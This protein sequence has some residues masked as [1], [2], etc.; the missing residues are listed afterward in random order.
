MA[1]HVTLRLGVIDAM[2]ALYHAFMDRAAPAKTL[3]GKRAREGRSITLADLCRS[4]RLNARRDRPY[5]RAA[6]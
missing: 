2:E 4:Q 1:C 3:R 6:T 5:A